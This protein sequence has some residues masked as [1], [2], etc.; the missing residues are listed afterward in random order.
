MDN[1]KYQVT[2]ILEKRKWNGE[3]GKK[4]V[5][6]NG[7]IVEDVPINAQITFRCKRLYYYTGCRIDK[8]CCDMIPCPDGKDFWQIRRIK[9]NK[10]NKRGETSAV[11]SS[12]LNQIRSAVDNVFK[13]MQ[14][15]GVTPTPANVREALKDELDEGRNSRMTLAECYNLFITEQGKADGWSKGTTTKH[16][17]ILSL[18]L[19]YQ[20]NIEFEDVTEQFLIGFATFLI[21]KKKHSNPYVAK[22]INDLKWFL[23]WATHRGF[24]KSLEYK[25][26]SPKKLKGVRTSDKK[27]V[28]TLSVD[29]FLHLYNLDIELPYLQRVRDVFCFC[30]ATGLRYSDAR[31][32]KWSDVKDDSI[33]FVTIK[34]D[35]PLK[36]DLNEFSKGILAKYE[37][38]R[39]AI[40][41]VLPVISN[42]KYNEYL[43][44]LGKLAGFDDE[45]T[46]VH[47]RGAE[48][49]EKTVKKY[50][51]MT[52]HIARKTF[53]TLSL[54][55]GIPAE[56]VR[57]YTGHKDARVMDRYVMF[58]DPTKT[59]AMKKFHFEETN[60]ETVFDYQITDE[61]R[62]VLGI[63]DKADY[64]RIV[65]ADES[66]A[67]LHLAFLFHLRGDSVKSL[68]CV[69]KLPDQLKIQ[70]IQHI[71]SK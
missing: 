53:V 38:N 71:T 67:A 46:T 60:K 27:N 17:T 44:E 64:I 9:V 10:V 55:A 23:N 3:P 24:N 19:E 49:I 25:Q 47:F 4:K 15:E 12:R 8:D 35:D 56:V 20:K 1:Y 59:S 51:L 29:E 28:I 58:T 30:C 26:Y 31:N 2:F 5:D 48:R 45:I 42:Q 65:E 70:Y 61:E 6:A 66:L 18:L 52:T 43:K 54:A 34:T 32:L 39:G 22:N 69:T 50:D 14:V 33:E 63:P 13:R 41:Y 21:D 57:S 68:E 62:A 36:V 40:N 11:I 7:V 16:K 37:H